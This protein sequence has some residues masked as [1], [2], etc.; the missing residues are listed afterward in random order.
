MNDLERAVEAIQSARTIVASTGAGISTESGIPDFRSPGGIWERYPV[1]EYATIEAFM[2]DP[3]KIWTFWRSLSADL[4]AFKPNPGHYALAEMEEFG[5]LS[6]V[7]TQNVDNLHQAAGSRRVVEY[8]GN[9][10]R[11]RCLTCGRPGDLTL[12]EGSGVPFCYCGGV[13]KPDVVLFGE[14]IPQQALLQ[15]QAY[16][17]TAEVVIIVGTS[18]QVYPAA[19]LPFTAKENG[20][21]IIECNVEETDFTRTITDVFLEGKA[22]TTLPLLAE[23]VLGPSG[24][25]S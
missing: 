1:E 11:L 25:P 9:N 15:A 13:Y 16:A 23:A 20:A 12:A 2:A 8:H 3:A 10:R 21:F 17:Q 22:G 6:A 18:A 19:Q 4:G 14:L 7:I 5:K 24:E